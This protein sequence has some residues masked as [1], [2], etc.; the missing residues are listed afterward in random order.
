MGPILT[1]LSLREYF[2]SARFYAYFLNII[3]EI[4]Y[5][6][7]GLFSTNPYPSVVNGQLWTIPYE[8]RCYAF[9]AVLA[10]LTI[11]ERR[12]LFAA[13]VLFFCIPFAIVKF[14]FFPGPGIPTGL[15]PGNVL[16]LSFLVAV[17]IYRYKDV[18]PWRFDLFI[19]SV[20]ISFV[21]L[22]V[23]HA[24][25]FLPLPAAYLTFYAGLLNPKKLAVMGL[26]ITATGYS[27]TVSR[28]N[29]SSQASACGPTIGMSVSPSRCR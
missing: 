4:H 29:N 9:L 27:S 28:S 2:A 12:A 24:D 5:E 14:W 18:I 1:V 10:V 25:Y 11:V 17:A 7:P 8:L 21:C 15:V 20:A 13:A 26:G 6:L 22:T 16:V 23:E 19:A 3:G